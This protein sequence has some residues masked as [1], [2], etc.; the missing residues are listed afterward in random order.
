MDWTE[1]LGAIVATLEHPFFETSFPES[2]DG[3]TASYAPLTLGNGREDSVA[4]FIKKNVTG[5]ANSK[6]ILGGGKSQ[7][8][9]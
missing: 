7:T 3:S 5:A 2:F 1:E 9:I 6:A 8:D 4:F